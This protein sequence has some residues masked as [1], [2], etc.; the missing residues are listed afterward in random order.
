MIT[1][2]NID[3]LAVFAIE[4]RR[5]SPTDTSGT[6]YGARRVWPGEQWQTV[7]TDYALGPGVEQYRRA[8]EQLAG[9][10]VILIGETDTGPLFL[11]DTGES[12]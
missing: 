3:D 12:Q 8:A 9:G 7:A 10:R 11:H 2:P 4:T 6:L 1:W 5:F